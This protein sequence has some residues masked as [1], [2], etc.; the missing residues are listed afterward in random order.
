MNRKY[1]ANISP[2]KTL[3][4]KFEQIFPTYFIW[5]VS[6]FDSH[7]AAKFLIYLGFDLEQIC[8]KG[9]IQ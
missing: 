3:L 8:R 9:L 6:M 7:R 5:H 2:T 1:I 4:R